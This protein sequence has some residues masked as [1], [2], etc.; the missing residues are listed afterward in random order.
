[1]ADTNQTQPVLIEP[2]LPVFTKQGE[3][4]VRPLVS[5]VI[6][7][8]NS[9]KTIRKCLAGLAAQTTSI[10]FEVIVVDSS[11]DGT[12]EIV[13]SDFPEVELVH[14]KGRRS[15]G[16]ARNCGFER[17]QGTIILFLDTDCVPNP[18][19][20]KEMVAG[21][22]LLD[23]DGVGGSVENGTPWSITGTTAFYL[24]FFRFLNYPGK[25][26]T[27]P[28]LMGGTSGFRRSVLENSRYPHRSVGDDFI[29]G[30]QQ[31]D[32]G[33]KLIFLPSVSV[34]HINKTGIRTVF[35]YQYKLGKGACTYRYLCS[36]GIMRIFEALPSLVFFMPIAVM[37]WVGWTVLRR[38]GILETLKFGVLLP[39]LIAGNGTWSLGFYRELIRR[40]SLKNRG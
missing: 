32:S 34:T 6:P 28:F 35:R 26:S 25:P 15:V 18:A 1:M 4:G 10:P 39:V 16:T 11:D 13:R 9:S 33:K 22:D 24:E 20:V 5:V 38:R 40:K 17:A 31:V 36:P 14:Y 37:P 12:E 23:A 27:T 2:R 8:Y 7:S 29:F 3:N 30:W 19:W 21:I